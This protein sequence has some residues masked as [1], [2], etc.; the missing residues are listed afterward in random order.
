M[1]EFL[2][3]LG[4]YKNRA[5]PECLDF[6]CAPW[7]WDW[8]VD[9][10]KYTEQGNPVRFTAMINEPAPGHV[11]IVGDEALYNEKQGDVHKWPDFRSYHGGTNCGLV[12][13]FNFNYLAY[14]E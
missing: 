7:H 13:K 1:R 12:P 8:D 4:P 3:E 14:A 11:F 2:G 5:G 10:K 9:W 6:N